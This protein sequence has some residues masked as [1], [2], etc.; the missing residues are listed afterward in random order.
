MA[1]QEMDAHVKPP[2]SFKS[3]YK[4]YQKIS[5]KNLDSDRDAID[6]SNLDDISKNS[7]SLKETLEFPFSTAQRCGFVTNNSTKPTDFPAVCVYEHHAIPGAH[8]VSQYIIHI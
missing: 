7:L 3:F 5:L 6:F 1:K 8:V 2:D 4:R